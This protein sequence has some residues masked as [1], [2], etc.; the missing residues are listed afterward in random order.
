[1]EAQTQEKSTG[2]KLGSA[3]DI[4]R[5]IIKADDFGMCHDG[6]QATIEELERDGIPYPDNF[7]AYLVRNLAAAERA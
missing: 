2:E 6:N 7:L 3:S 1:M 5:L 4:R